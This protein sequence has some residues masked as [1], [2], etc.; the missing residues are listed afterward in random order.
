MAVWTDPLL[1]KIKVPQDLKSQ[2]FQLGAA[3]FQLLDKQYQFL[4]AKEEFLGY[5]SGYGGGKT[6]VGSK[7]AAHLSCLRPGNRGL[8]GMEAN[9]DLE[10]TAQRDLLDFLYEAHLLKEPPNSKNHR[11]LVHCIDEKTGRNLGLDS[12]ITFVHLDDPKHVRGRHLGWFWIDEGS[13][14]SKM[15]EAWQNLIGRLRLPAFRGHYQAFVTGN[16]EGHNWIYDF[17]FNREILEAL[18]CGGRPGAHAWDCPDRNDQ[19]CNRRMRLKRRAF[20]ATSYENYFL[21]PE[22]I[23]QMTASF[24]EEERLRYIEGSFDIFTGMIF[25]EWNEDVHVLQVA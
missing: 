5:I 14:G 7:K 9:T 8:V 3:K 1:P 2:T 18:T 4:A 21:P 20:H 22:Y 12:E 13:K 15:R 24:T 17:F 23:S 19:L 11:A 25:K 6:S 10:E 16:P